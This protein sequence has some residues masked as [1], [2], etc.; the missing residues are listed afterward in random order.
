MAIMDREGDGG[1]VVVT[2][3]AVRSVACSTPRGPADSAAVVGRR[4]QRDGRHGAYRVARA[5]NLDYAVLKRRAAQAGASGSVPRPRF[6]ELVAPQGL[7]MPA[8]A[9]ESQCVVEMA[10]PWRDDAPATARQ[11]A[12]R[13]AGPVPS[14]LEHMM[15]QITPHMR[16]WLA[17]EP[18]DFRAGID[19]LAAACRQC[20][21]AD[22]FSGALFVFRNRA[23][24]QSRFSC[25]T[26]RGF[27]FAA[28]VFRP[29]ILL[30][31]RPPARPGARCR[32]AN[33][34][35]C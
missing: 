14:V 32:R 5:L 2:E 12:G 13:P 35:C 33:F 8:P 3:A 30:S 31:G 17:V 27:G 10:A 6:V 19:G 16:I 34:R 29:G 26:G 15:I 25:M 1:G 24:R 23:A 18:I 28:S 4:G 9:S 20:L 7:P 21:Q 22:P 11:R